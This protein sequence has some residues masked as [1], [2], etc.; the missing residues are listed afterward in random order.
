MRA[1]VAL[2]VLSIEGGWGENYDREWDMLTN[3]MGMAV[4][5]ERVV[6]VKI[7][8]LELDLQ[9]LKLEVGHHRYCFRRDIAAAA[10]V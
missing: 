4:E 1:C 2:F 9:I 8:K 6:R 10:V 5:E 3:C 7:A